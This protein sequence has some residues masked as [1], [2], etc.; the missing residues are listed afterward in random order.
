MSIISI[1]TFGQ[2]RIHSNTAMHTPITKLSIL[3][4]IYQ[5]VNISRLI[6]YVQFYTVEQE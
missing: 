5:N 3:I 4:E 1:H 6:Q 2:V